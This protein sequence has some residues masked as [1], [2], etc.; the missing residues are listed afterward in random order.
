MKN[1]TISLQ[2]Y[3]FAIILPLFTIIALFSL[4]TYHFQTNISQLE[5]KSI[6]LQGINWMQYLYNDL[7]EIYLLESKEKLSAAEFK[8]LRKLINTTKKDTDL[9]KNHLKIH[10]KKY[11]NIIE[12]NN[13]LHDI[14]TTL[15]QSD[16]SKNIQQI[17]SRYDSYIKNIAKNSD[18][19][20]DEE[21]VT[22]ILTNA[23][24]YKY[25]KLFELLY[26]NQH[27]KTQEILQNN[28]FDTQHILNIPN[29]PTLE[30]LKENYTQNS[31]KLVY[32]YDNR[33]KEFKTYQNILVLLITLTILYIIYSYVMYL[34]KNSQLIFMQKEFEKYSIIDKLTGL[35]NR[36]HFDRTINRK[37]K[38]TKRGNHSLVFIIININNFKHFNKIYGYQKG[39]I[40]LQL[41]SKILKN[42]L[43]RSED[44][45]FRL[46]DKEFGILMSDM[47]YEKAL[48]FA[49]NIK[50]KIDSADI[51]YDLN[52]DPKN[53]KLTV[54]LALTYIEKNEEYEELEI[55]S[56]TYKAIETTKD[57]S[58][59]TI[60]V[61]TPST[62]EI[63]L[64]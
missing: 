17:L 21:Y 60:S 14:E 10:S 53:Q 26:Q 20:V 38:S 9:F 32:I 6:S 57:F 28:L 41:I 36:D 50:Q 2:Y 43:N 54:A 25:P 22:N 61:Y 12:I 58:K 42:T 33:I 34:N 35:Y 13:L 47:P 19:L 46:A 45:I 30:N 4:G 7:Q 27:N 49:Q 44:Y 52:A 5:K 31:D 11:Q 16:K 15:L 18:F 40:I 55:F 8:S 56:G 62:Q 1:Y 39:N 29:K 37:L 59:S 63:Q 3:I 24:V 64:I 23:M 51:Q 48:E